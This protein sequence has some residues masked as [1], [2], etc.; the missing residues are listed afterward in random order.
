[1]FMFEKGHI[2]VFNFVA[3]KSSAKMIVMSSS[4]TRSGGTMVNFLK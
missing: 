4:K 3:L 1:M 2:C